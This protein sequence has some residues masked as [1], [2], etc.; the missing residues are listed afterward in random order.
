MIS[1][2]KKSKSQIVSS[3]TFR[4]DIK[5]PNSQIKSVK[6]P[7]K[8]PADKLIS[9]ISDNN[10]LAHIVKILS[11][12][13]KD[14]TKL[15]IRFLVSHFSEN[16]N[17]FK[18]L[19]ANNEMER[20]EAIMSVIKIERYETDHRIIKYGEDGEKFYIILKGKTRAL[21][22]V[23]VEKNM[24][25]KEYIKCLNHIKFVE[26]DESKLKRYEENNRNLINYSL[27]KNSNYNISYITIDLEYN[28]V[29]RV[30]E[31][32]IIGFR[33]EGDE[34]GEVAL[35]NKVPRTATM[36]ADGE[37][38]LAVLEK[39]D[40]NRILKEMEDNKN[41]ELMQ[42][43]RANYLIFR[44]WG[45]RYFLKLIMHLKKVNF[46]SGTILYKQNDN[47]DSFFLTTKG[48]FEIC[49]VVDINNSESFIDY[50]NTPNKKSIFKLIQS[51]K[52]QIPDKEFNQIIDK[53]GNLLI[54]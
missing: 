50:I 3:K 14:R 4:R 26:L 13:S 37:C 8:N 12:L 42:E 54:I 21:K 33:K 32:K 52:T 36:I 6:S 18:N 46:S 45:K 5:Q 47:S 43:I 41:Q 24:T 10:E 51:V 20:L 22:P 39:N 40:Y 17:F 48:Q 11:K 16:F 7:K 1:S 30:E 28:K 2:S 53:I 9:E 38:F 34:F 44:N 49:S 31:E 35:I 23:T 19:K 27:L 15:E 29:F 25:A